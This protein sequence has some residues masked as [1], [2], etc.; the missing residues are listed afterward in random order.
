[1]NLGICNVQLIYY[2][3]GEG[4]TL[5]DFPLIRS[6]RSLCTRPIPQ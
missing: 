2:G 6:L 5:R 3:E 4:K 1:M